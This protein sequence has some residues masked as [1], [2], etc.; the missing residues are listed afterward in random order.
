MNGMSAYQEAKR[1]AARLRLMGYPEAT[2]AREYCIN[3][4]IGI[5]RFYTRTVSV[6]VGEYRP[7]AFQRILKRFMTA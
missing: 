5:D 2:A 6:Y 3:G 7:N 4:E 1:T